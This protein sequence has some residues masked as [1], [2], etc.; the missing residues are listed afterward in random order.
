L[1]DLDS[2]GFPLNRGRIK[3]NACACIALSVVLGKAKAVT[4]DPATLGMPT[5][6]LGFN[7]DGKVTKFGDFVPTGGQTIAQSGSLPGE[8]GFA[9]TFPGNPSPHILANADI[10]S[11]GDLVLT[12]L[13]MNYQIGISG[14]AGTTVPVQLH[15]VLSITGGLSTAEITLHYGPV[16]EFVRNLIFPGTDPVNNTLMLTAGNAYLVTLQAI[17]QVSSVASGQAHVSTA[18]VDPYWN[19]DPTFPNA[20]QYSLVFSDGI[21]NSPAAVPGPIAGAG[22]PGLILAGGGLLGWW[23]RRQKTA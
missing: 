3:V 17:A 23:R 8:S 15:G 2:F 5:Y 10:G 14:P 13:S 12:N 7:I 9:S 21:E 19:I 11:L 4:I 18:R 6:S 20:D 22:L 16:T 1:A